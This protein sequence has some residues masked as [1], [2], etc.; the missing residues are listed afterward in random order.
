MNTDEMV[1]LMKVEDYE[2]IG[3]ISPEDV[4]T[5][6]TLVTPLA[7]FIEGAWKLLPLGARRQW[8]PGN[9]KVALFRKDFSGVNTS[10]FWLFRPE[11]NIQ[12][13]ASTPG[14][15]RYF[16]PHE[17]EPAPLAQILDWTA[18][19]N[20]PFDVPD[21]L[22][23]G[24]DAQDCYCQRVYIS[25]QS[26]LFGPVRLELSGSGYRP[27]E[28]M[29]SSSTGGQ[30]LFVWMYTLPED[31]VLNLAETHTQI[32]L[33]DE[34]MLGTPT[35][36]EDWSLPQVTIKQALLASNEAPATV[37]GTVHLVDK[38][39]RE[40]A[41]L[42]SSEGPRALHID[43]V[44]LR[45]AQYIL[46][47]QVDSLQDLRDVVEQLTRTHPL[48]K[49]ARELEIQARSQ[50]IEQEAEA[51]IH[52]KKE[53]LQQLHCQIQEA[54]TALEHLQS[55]ANEA[56]EGQLQAIAAL[57]AFEQSARERLVT[58]KEEPMRVLAE[59]HI[60]AS[61]LHML[62]D[63]GIQPAYEMRIPPPSTSTAQETHN[64]ELQGPVSA[65]GLDWG[66]EADTE[67][68]YAPLQELPL[69][70]WRQV[71]QQAGVNA[72]D[73]RVCAAALL[74]GLIPAITGEAAIP[75]LRAVAQFIARGRVALAPV[76]VTAL[77]TLDL[78][79]GVDTL[80]QAF[81]PSGGLADCILE[82]Q[83]HPDELL[84]V[85]LEGIDRVPGMPTYMPLLRQYI[86]VR[87]L[88]G[89]A[90]NIT[91][92][93]LFHPRSITA[94]DPYLN[95]TRFTW[96]RNVLL[97]ATLDDDL[98]SLPLPPVSDRWLV[99]M[100]PELKSEFT[101]S[102]HT[103]LMLSDVS[104]E[105]WEGWIQE[106][107]LQ[108]A[109]KMYTLENLDRRQRLFHTALTMLHFDEK[110]ADAIVEDSWLEQFK[111]AEEEAK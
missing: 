48:V 15:S 95:L 50:E 41:R 94:R 80:R 19:T 99:R 93:N 78:F 39:I 69:Q 76:P 75:A 12:L 73:V 79:G 96:P 87:Q 26:R 20:N 17:L 84:A 16:V 86:E 8:F 67:I 97:V 77:T 72:K 45:R 14:Y 32:T 35:G 22:D 109:S 51:R 11:Q 90:G 54:E 44:T 5:S 3:I 49:M 38:R 6:V 62:V 88:E 24:I 108:A 36:K 105:Q 9:G 91:P 64:S 40:L 2:W 82:A 23:Q 18:R 33:L 55:A 1:M 25:C 58:L 101:P 47:N 37:E 66:Q 63:G 110:K 29:Q 70:K 30:S 81:I 98:N 27:R 31:G 65:S 13:S 4:K 61:L 42:S 103:G 89:D 60:T 59:H 28:Y 102:P 107:R 111:P 92:V 106:I 21:L 83:A 43:P 7:Y 104:L 56:R 71:T 52:E 100:N 53:Q 46:S 57:N 85:I 68:N 34:S 10:R 74:A